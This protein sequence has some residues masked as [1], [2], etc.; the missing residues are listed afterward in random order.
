M[1][2]LNEMK[3]AL[4]NEFIEIA[5]QLEAGFKNMVNSYIEVNV[6]PHIDSIYEQLNA[7]RNLRKLNDIYVNDAFKLLNESKSLIEDLHKMK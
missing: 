2:A 6:M 4:R 1:S 7:V 5:D 3:E